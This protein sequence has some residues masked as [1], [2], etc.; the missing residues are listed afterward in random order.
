MELEIIPDNTRDTDNNGKTSST[1]TTRD[2]S[3][4]RL[5]AT[6]LF[7]T[8]PQ[9]SLD[10]TEALQLLTEALKKKKRTISEYLIAKEKHKDGN[11]HLHVWLKLDKKVDIRSA[12]LLDLKNH[13]GNYQSARSSSRVKAYCSKEG[14]FIAHPPYVPTAKPSPWKTAI[15]LAKEGK[16][17][18]AIQSLEDGGERVC[19]DLVLHQASIETSLRIFEPPQLL[20]FARPLTSYGEL[21]TW[22]KDKV[23]LILVGATNTGKTTLAA[24]LL[25]TAL[26]TRHLDL[27]VQLR[28]HEGVILDDMSFKHLHDEAQIALLDVE[29]ETHVH[30]RYR[31]ATLPAGLPR[32]LTSNKEPFEIINMS[33]PAIA[34]RV[35]AIRWYGWDNDP[36]W[37]ECV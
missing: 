4:F 11:D 19:R 7:L 28:G 13:H 5:N 26:F 32:I 35:M 27:L 25:P 29:M 37:E 9:C 23:A 12:S 31:V 24:S 3:T 6:Q 33:N 34:R 20:T 8:Y 18:E 15:A 30:V 16:T 1:S 14:D 21:F 17:K 22:A 2:Q 36:M 10:P